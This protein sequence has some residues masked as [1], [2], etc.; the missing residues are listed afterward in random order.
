[1]YKSASRAMQ[2]SHWRSRRVHRQ[3]SQGPAAPVIVWPIHVTDGMKPD[4]TLR[5]LVFANRE[6]ADSAGY[7]WGGRA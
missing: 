1:M 5:V 6:E 2:R 7:Q 3:Q 4:G